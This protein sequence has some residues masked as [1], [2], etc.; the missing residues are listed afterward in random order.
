MLITRLF[1]LLFLPITAFA[2]SLEI[3]TINIG[4]G[5]ATLVLVRNMDSL[6]K[7]FTMAGVG[8]PADN[9]NYLDTALTKGVMLRGTVKKA[10]LIDFGNGTK[11]GNKIIE[12]LQNMGIEKS[13]TLTAL[14]LT[15]NHKD[16][17]GG[18]KTII[19]IGDYKAPVYYRGDGKLKDSKVAGPM[20]NT[21]FKTPAGKSLNVVDVT[22]TQIDLGNIAGQNIYLTAVSSDGYIYRSG[23]KNRILSNNEND[24][25]CSWL[26]QY[27]AF[28]YFIGG[29]ISGA[30]SGSSYSNI[31]EPL[32][33]SLKKYDPASFLSFINTKDTVHKGHI[34][35]FKVDHH[36]SGHSSSPYFLHSISPLAAI[37]SCGADY[38]HPT[39][40]FTER[41]RDSL[42]LRPTDLIRH[43]NSLKNWYF[44]S[45][46]P[47]F[48]DRRDSIGTPAD[49]GIIGGNITLIVD[50]NNIS[51]QS[52]YEI[53]WDGNY[54]PSMV[55]GKGK[56]LKIM[57]S[58]N[59]P[60]NKIYECH[61]VSGSATYF[62]QK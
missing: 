7:A 40:E 11:Q 38:D 49:P 18:F 29:D 12:H 24:Y 62:I 10:V 41:L 4:H 35:A 15:H 59:P 46:L 58:P 25:G 8:Y 3:H 16:H 22:N 33:D 30:S 17:Y 23:K 42:K 47:G 45:L 50:D 44:T 28:R 14:I 37:T 55:T 57:R 54:D 26:L 56:P 31:E 36:G 53:R 52:R 1:L 43:P 39:L 19:N 32:A 60:G 13:D 27:G 34:C 5:D 20:F 9:L 2:Q 21:G 48:K 6:K 51:T 61:K